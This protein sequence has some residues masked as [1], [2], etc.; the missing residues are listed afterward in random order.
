M[1]LVP[2]LRVFNNTAGYVDRGGGKR[3][4]SIAMYSEHRHRIGIFSYYAKNHGNEE[5]RCRD[6]FYTQLFLILFMKRVQSNGDESD[7]NVSR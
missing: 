3:N 7:I 6:L 5:D 4:G 2:M 1:V